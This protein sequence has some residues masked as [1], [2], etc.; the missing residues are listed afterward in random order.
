MELG[1]SVMASEMIFLY[2]IGDL[3]QLAPKS[4]LVGSTGIISV[5]VWVSNPTNMGGKRIGSSSC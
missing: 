1:L 3:N 5:V 4:I 2:K